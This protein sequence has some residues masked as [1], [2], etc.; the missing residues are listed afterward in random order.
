MSNVAGNANLVFDGYVNGITFSFVE[1]WIGILSYTFQIYFD[2]YGYSMVAIGLGLLFG[3]IKIA[4]FGGW[5]IN[6]VPLLKLNRF[7]P[8]HASIPD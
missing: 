4:V 5:G 2:F 6:Q 3:V 8:Q 7:A 1:T